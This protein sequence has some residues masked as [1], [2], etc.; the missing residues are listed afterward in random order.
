MAGDRRIGRL[1]CVC[2][3]TLAL[4]ALTGTAAEAPLRPDLVETAISVAQT[5]GS[6]RVTDVVRNFGGTTAPR[7]TTGYFIAHVRIGGRSVASLRP[8]TSSRGTRK[9]SIPM[10]IIPGFYRVVVCA[11]VGKRIRESNERNDC[12]ST[13]RPVEVTDRTPPAFAGLDAA[14]TC[15]PGP[16]DGERFTPYYL[17][18]R[19]A[20][21]NGTPTRELVYDVYQAVSPGGESFSTPTHTT[22]PG[23]TSFTTPRLSS[24]QSHY[25]VVRA[26][27]KAGNRDLNTVERAGVNLCL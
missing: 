7:S 21:D 27:D 8:G 25:F 18:W 11:D 2:T 6:V 4:L 17:R 24:K 3:A 1:G 15:I 9:M 23:A 10:S 5:G 12:L 13:S 20:T 14:T 19:A 16:V 26:R 22:Q